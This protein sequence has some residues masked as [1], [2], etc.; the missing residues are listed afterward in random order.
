MPNGNILNPIDVLAPLA[1]QKPCGPAKSDF[2]AAA[3]QHGF[4]SN[5]GNNPDPASLA[6]VYRTARAGQPATPEATRALK[7]NQLWRPL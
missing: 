3:A 7:R 2:F 5:Q 6:A 1:D 4:R